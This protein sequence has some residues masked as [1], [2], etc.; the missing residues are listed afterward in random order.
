MLGFGNMG[1]RMIVLEPE[2]HCKAVILN[3]SSNGKIELFVGFINFRGMGLRMPDSPTSSLLTRHPE[4][5][6]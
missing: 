6:R 1:V 5:L 3:L 4:K 2:L